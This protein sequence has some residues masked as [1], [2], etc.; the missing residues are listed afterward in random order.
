MQGCRQN[1]GDS[2]G[3]N[4]A[5]RSTSAD[6]PTDRRTAQSSFTASRDGK[7]GTI[8]PGTCTEALKMYMRD[9][10]KA[11][12]V[13]NC[14]ECTGIMVRIVQGVHQSIRETAVCRIDTYVRVRKH[15]ISLDYCRRH[16]T[17]SDQARAA[18]PMGR[19]ADL[20]ASELDNREGVIYRPLAG[21]ITSSTEFQTKKAPFN[22]NHHTWQG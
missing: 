6:R 13:R 22:I 16:S 17:S 2:T 7:T 12:N 18:V 21:V 19:W 14:A 10:Q 11:V 3:A 9:G 8:K 15:R 1:G 4:K 5:I 20:P